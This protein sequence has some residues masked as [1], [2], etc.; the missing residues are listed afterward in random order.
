M[1]RIN[2]ARTLEEII[3][4]TMDG[5]LSDYRREQEELHGRHHER[6]EILK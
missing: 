4:R 1:G 3:V 5:A 6:S 2:T